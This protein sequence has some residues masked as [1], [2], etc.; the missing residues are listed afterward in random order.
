MADFVTAAVESSDSAIQLLIFRY[1]FVSFVKAVCY[2]EWSSSGSCPVSISG[3]ECCDEPITVAARHKAWTVFVHPN[4][5]IV[6][7]NPTWG[8]DVCVRIFCVCAALCAGIGFETGWSPSKESYRLCQRSLT[9]S[10]SLALPE[11]PPIVQ[12]L[13]NFPA[14]YGTWRFITVPTRALH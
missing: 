1:I 7:S 9:H 10:W 4:T 2:V 6:D 3:V 12:L 5:G 13:K 8:M 11:K 14:F